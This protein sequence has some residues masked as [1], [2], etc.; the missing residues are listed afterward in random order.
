[1][2]IARS[3]LASFLRRA[4]AAIGLPAACLCASVQSAACSDGLCSW[5]CGGYH[6]PCASREIDECATGG[7]YIQQSCGCKYS[8]CDSAQQAACAQLTTA[9][10]C[11]QETMCLWAQK[12]TGK[13]LSCY[14]IHDETACREAACTW[15]ENCP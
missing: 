13:P 2:P 11:K 7:C 9:E 10:D 8:T 1:M 5:E 12:C 4:A 3:R 14:D 6:A 15:E